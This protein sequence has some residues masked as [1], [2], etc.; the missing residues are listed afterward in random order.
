MIFNADI[1]HIH[2]AI[3]DI[4][5]RF[6]ILAYPPVRCQNHIRVR[7][8]HTHQCDGEKPKAADYYHFYKALFQYASRAEVQTRVHKGRITINNF[9]RLER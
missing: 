9:E 1:S 3:Q 2:H 6:V 7:L 4:S 5:D 8:A